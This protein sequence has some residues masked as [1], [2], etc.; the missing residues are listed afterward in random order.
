M[1]EKLELERFDVSAERGFLPARD[2]LQRLSPIFKSL[3]DALVKMPK[4]LA[5]ERWGECFV[6]IPSMN[7][8]LLR[9]DEYERAFLLLSFA[10]QGRI[11]EFHRKEV[12]IPLISENVA[13]PLSQ[14][15]EW[16]DRPPIMAYASYALHNWR[17]LDRSK[18]IALGNIVLMQNFLGGMDEEW[19]TLIHIEIEARA[20][21]ALEAAIRAQEAML[22]D[23]AGA[24][25]AHLQDLVHALTLLY[26]TFCRMPER[27]DPYIYYHRVR[28]WIHGTY[29]NRLFPDG[30]VYEGVE[31]H[32]GKPQKFRGETGAQSSIVPL[33]DHVLSVEHEKN[34]LSEHLSEIR[35]H[36]P[37]GHRRLIEEIEARPS[38]REYV[39]GMPFLIP[40]FN[41]CVEKLADFRRKHLE[42]AGAYIDTQARVDSKGNAKE[43]GTGG[44]PYMPSLLKHLQE[45][46]AAKL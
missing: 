16:L 12:G 43:I 22:A 15:A 9:E 30:V 2:P 8:R 45:T 1:S 29:N 5:A 17:R 4:L 19:F 21:K 31:K 40:W 25:L 28:P 7:P 44:T 24:L 6:R 41:S 34:I 13:V 26:Q 18:P 20:G 42:Y 27:C 46:I 23:D 35:W 32:Q 33:L 3:E 11:F 36:M 38:L 14:L 39:S 37:S 10:A